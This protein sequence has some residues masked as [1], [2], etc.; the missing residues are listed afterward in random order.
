MPVRT[1][2]PWGESKTLFNITPAA[3]ASNTPQ[4]EEPKQLGRSRLT[5][6]ERQRRRK[7][8]FCFYCGE[9]NHTVAQYPLKDQTHQVREDAC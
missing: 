8:H 4:L 1:S 9:S 6:K 7:L 3:C 5:P 2:K